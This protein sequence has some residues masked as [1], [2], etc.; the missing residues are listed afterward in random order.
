MNARIYVRVF[1][2]VHVRMC[3]DVCFSGCAFSGAGVVFVGCKHFSF[4]L[5]YTRFA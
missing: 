2:H 3:V 1:L 4:F 5:G